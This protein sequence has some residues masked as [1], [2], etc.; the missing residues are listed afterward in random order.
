MPP[1]SAFLIVT[2]LICARVSCGMID[3]SHHRH[4]PSIHLSSKGHPRRPGV[5]SRTFLSLSM[6]HR[7]ST[8]RILCLVLGPACGDG[9]ST[10]HVCTAA[11]GL[12]SGRRAG[13]L[14]CSIGRS[15]FCPTSVGRAASQ[16]CSMVCD[17]QN[18]CLAPAVHDLV[19]FPCPRP[20]CIFSVLR[21]IKLMLRTFRSPSP[22][23]KKS[24]GPVLWHNE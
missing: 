19:S 18:D 13:L 20:S 21:S 15:H 11:G 10:L 23:Q 17:H 5:H 2:L 7:G 14:H 1:A 6:D 8:C 3:F 12:G 22:S 4:R 9:V 24:S 16:P